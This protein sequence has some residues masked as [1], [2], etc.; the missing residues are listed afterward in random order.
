MRST[1]SNRPVA[2]L[3]AVITIPAAILLHTD[4]FGFGSVSWAIAIPVALLGNCF[5]AYVLTAWAAP[6]LASTGGREGARAADP[7][8]VR[9]A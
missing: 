7:D 5:L 4:P 9:V 3:V 2:V 8:D 6:Y 1:L